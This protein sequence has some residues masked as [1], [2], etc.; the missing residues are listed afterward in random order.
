MDSSTGVYL[1]VFILA[2][3]LPGLCYVFLSFFLFLWVMYWGG[4]YEIYLPQDDNLW[5]PNKDVSYG[6]EGHLI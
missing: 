6:K 1:F 4:K 3:V 2:C 5:A